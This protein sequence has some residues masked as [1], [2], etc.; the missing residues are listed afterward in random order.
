MNTPMLA[1]EQKCTTI[2]NALIDLARAIRR[3]T[4]D[5]LIEENAP[6]EDDASE[7]T[8][9]RKRIIT[10]YGAILRDEVAS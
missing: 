4:L 6:S 7:D 2:A 8:R 1:S 5:Q 10:E 9:L 3:R